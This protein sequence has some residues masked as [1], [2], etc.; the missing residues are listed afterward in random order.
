MMFS[1]VVQKTSDGQV[2]EFP[3]LRGPDVPVQDPDHVAALASEAL[4]RRIESMLAR[5]EI[6]QR[7]EETDEDGERLSVPVR[8]EMAVALQVK[9]MRKEL[10]LTLTE[11]AHRMGVS[12][13]R[14]TVLETPTCNWTLATLLR[15]SHALDS[16]LEIVFRRKPH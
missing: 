12:R 8:A 7:P 11:L 9:W 2:L 16:E 15:L 5:G 14:V 10:G 6:P 13:Q 1:A 3:E 4:N